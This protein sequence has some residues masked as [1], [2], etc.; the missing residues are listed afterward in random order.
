MKKGKLPTR[1]SYSEA[2][3]KIP[4]NFLQQKL[5]E[6]HLE[7]YVQNGIPLENMKVIIPDGTKISF[8]NTPETREQYGESEGHY[9]QSS[10][11]GFYELSTRTFEDFKFGHIKKSERSLLLEH[12]STNTEPTL[13][14]ADAGYNGMGF[15]E[16][17]VNNNQNILMQL[18]SCALVQSFRK[19]KKRSKIVEIK[20]TK[21]HL[22]SYPDYQHLIGKTVTIRLIRTRGTSKLRSQILITTLLD[23]VKYSWTDLAK[24]Y[25]Q[26][27][28]VELA[29][30]HLK[31][32]IQI[33]KIRKRNRLAIEQSL[34]A[35]IILY[36]LA[37]IIRNRVKKPTLKI[38][39][40]G[41]KM[42]CFSL[43]IELVHTFT[44]IGIALKYGDKRKM[45]KALK[46][47]RSC[48]FIY[49]PWRSTPRIC[50]TPQSSFAGENRER[51]KQEILK[52]EFLKTEFEILGVEY[53]QLR[54]YS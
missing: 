20:L 15:I 43:C 9:A 48:S 26:R 42:L 50:H 49:K 12:I 33:E 11:V 46:A 25:R 34:Y 54:I 13:Y 2:C 1:Q 41:I 10:A 44:C 6:S 29:F 23:E 51:A 35:A 40:G 18:K 38:E 45:D 19:S 52:T 31:V 3:K 30:R 8:A 32:K 17:I 5:K 37:T 53:K 4:V 14:L 21:N 36:N 27:Y 7:E 28:S 39:K 16:I 22:K 47:I 24:L